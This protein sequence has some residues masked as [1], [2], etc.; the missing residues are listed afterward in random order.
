MPVLN[1]AASKLATI[2][3][4]LHI[5]KAKNDA[6]RCNALTLPSKPVSDSSNYLDPPRVTREK[7]DTTYTM[8]ECRNSDAN[9]K[10]DEKAACLTTS[11]PSRCD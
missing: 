6:F 11:Q 9:T 1:P 3:H 4:S 8:N 2:T 10:A 5:F 7:Q